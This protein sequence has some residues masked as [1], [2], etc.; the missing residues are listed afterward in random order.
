[1]KNKESH[2]AIKDYIEAKQIQKKIIEMQKRAKQSSQYAK[3]EL[4]ELNEKKLM[5][6]EYKSSY[7]PLL[8]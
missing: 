3:L 1:M 8:Q 5:P 6:S 2:H 7:G 4:K